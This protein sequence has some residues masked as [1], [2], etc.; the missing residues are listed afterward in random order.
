[1]DIQ[2]A[3][4]QVSTLR[5]K[6][7]I[8]TQFHWTNFRGSFC[9]DCLS[10]LLL[11]SSMSLPSRGILYLMLSER[12]GKSLCSVPLASVALWKCHC[13]QCILNAVA[14]LALCKVNKPAYKHFLSLVINKLN[15]SFSF[16]NLNYIWKKKPNNKNFPFHLEDELSFLSLEALFQ[17]MSQRVTT[18][19]KK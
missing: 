12:Q 17:E 3:H 18:P 14:I 5:E 10:V 4:P 7:Q 11:C 13:I 16:S 19:T 15:V 9:A 8:L 1:M 6:S 2:T